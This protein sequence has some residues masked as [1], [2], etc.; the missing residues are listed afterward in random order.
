MGRNQE[1]Q[2]RAY[3]EIK[4]VSARY[5][6]KFTYEALQDMTYLE[7]V[8]HGKKLL[9]K[10]KRALSA[11]GGF[12]FFLTP[13]SQRLNPAVLHMLKVS[14]AEYTLPKFGEQKE[15]VKIYPGTTVIIPTRGIH[16]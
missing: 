10:Y 16:L 2:Q 14:T 8:I 3:E 15:G 1:V 6:N 11:N 9:V 5:E 12:N 13:E 4:E 7:C